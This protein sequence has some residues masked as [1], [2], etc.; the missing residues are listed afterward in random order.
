M[1]RALIFLN[2]NQPKKSLIEKVYKTTDA[3]ICADGGTRRALFCGLTPTVILGDFDSL[4][5]KI[6]KQM[7]KAGVSLISF[8]REKDYTDSEL[9]INFAIDAGYKELILFGVFGARIDHFVANIL[10]ASQIEK[11]G[12]SIRIMED[13]QTLY[14]TDTKL[15]IPGKAGDTV[16]LISLAGDATVT[17]KGLKYAL[18]RG[19][20]PFGKTIG[21]SNELISARA[22]I[23]VHEGNMLIIQTN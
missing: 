9:A 22:E 23:R 11:R 20:I 2:G 12:M 21:V 17:T 13:R 14:F 1:K 4:S 6:Q 5:K 19:K 7:Q 3:V 8:P 10:F 16:S 15:T 18:T